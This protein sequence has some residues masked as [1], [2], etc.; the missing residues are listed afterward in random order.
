MFQVAFKGNR[1]LYWWS[2]LIW[3]GKDVVPCRFRDIYI[4]LSLIRLANCWKS[5]N[6]YCCLI[7]FSFVTGVSINLSPS[8]STPTWW[9]V[10]AWSERFWSF[11]SFFCLSVISRLC[12]ISFLRFLRLLFLDSLSA[13]V[14]IAAVCSEMTLMTT[15]LLSLWKRVHIRSFNSES[16]WRV[17][18]CQSYWHQYWQCFSRANVVSHLCS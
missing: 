17:V 7:L 13:I 15:C 3:H 8:A 9:S 18:V 16:W 4:Y 1:G 11:F 14:G 6:N 10:S 5:R 2:S 12:I